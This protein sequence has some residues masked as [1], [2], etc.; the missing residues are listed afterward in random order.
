[1]NTSLLYFLVLLIAGLPLAAQE[2]ASH[3]WEDRV[4]IVMT[5]DHTDAEFKRQIQELNAHQQGLTER[6]LK[7]YLATP[8]AYRL[9]NA[10]ETSWKPGGDLYKTYNKRSGE[11]E[12]LLIGLD[13]QPKIRKYSFTTALEL[14]VTIDGMPMRQSEMRN[15]NKGKN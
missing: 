3:Q 12:V 7:V 14:F 15:R 5:K 9:L 4:L 13:G 1:M 11:P 6:K 2:I 8:E 10:P